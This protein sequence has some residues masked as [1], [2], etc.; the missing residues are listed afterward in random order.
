V[1][2]PNLGKT[3]FQKFKKKFF[4]EMLGFELARKV[5]YHSSRASSPSEVVL[6]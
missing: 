3:G 1:F 4:L 6:F 5:L 2:V